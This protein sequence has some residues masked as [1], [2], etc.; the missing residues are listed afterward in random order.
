M[1][2]A[3]G[4]TL[5]IGVGREAVVNARGSGA[6]SGGGVA[7]GEPVCEFGT[8]ARL[9]IDQ[10]GVARARGLVLS[11]RCGEYGI[12]EMDVSGRGAWFG[13]QVVNG[14]D[15]AGGIEMPFDEEAVG[16]HAAMERAGG[17]AVKIGNVAAGEGA[18]TIEVEVGIFGF[19]RIKG[20]FDETNAASEGV[21]TLGEFEL[22]ADATIAMG[23]ED[24]GHVGVE[25]RS[26]IVKADECFGEAD[27]LAA[28]EGA[29]DLAAGMVGNDVSDVRFGIEFGVSPNL[30]GDLDAAVEVVEGV[31]RTNDDVGHVRCQI[32]VSSF[33]FWVKR[34]RGG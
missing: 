33:W 12:G 15:N 21:F 34:V 25:V 9:K 27:H 10:L 5:K 6:D 29:E 7:F 8:D 14:R 24:R 2:A 13:N 30:A 28:I 17:D 3:G 23:R 19:E 22:T 32:Y 26:V 11:C 16:G 31:E 20:P 4:M 1:I 18:Q